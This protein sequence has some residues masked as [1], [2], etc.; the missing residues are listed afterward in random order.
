MEKA[1]QY[2][3]TRT[4]G[5]IHPNVIKLVEKYAG[6]LSENNFISA[7][8]VENFMGKG[9]VFAIITKDNVID[10][11]NGPFFQMAIKTIS[12]VSNLTSI[13]I[14]N[15]A[16][17]K[18]TLFPTVF[19]K[20]EIRSLIIQDINSAQSAGSSVQTAS[21]AEELSKFKKLLDDGV[22]TQEEFDK[23]KAQI[24]GI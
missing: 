15:T 2:R 20:K 18:F 22:L 19:V 21:G 24:L 6:N 23:K 8:W 3:Y 7:C 11:T 10:N 9:K 12:T 17:K 16:G 1:G 4:F 14:V 5:E 13:E